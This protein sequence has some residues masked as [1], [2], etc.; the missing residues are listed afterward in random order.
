MKLAALA[1]VVGTLGLA[2]C[3]TSDYQSPRV[4]GPVKTFSK[5]CNNTWEACAIK[6]DGDCKKMGY[7]SHVPVKRSTNWFGKSLEYTC[8]K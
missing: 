5:G 6:A 3:T 7:D 8:Q 2:A 1:L 4:V